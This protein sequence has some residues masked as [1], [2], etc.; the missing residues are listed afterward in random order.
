MLKLEDARKTGRYDEQELLIKKPTM[1]G[2]NPN[3]FDYYIINEFTTEETIKFQ[4]QQLVSM[5]SKG[6]PLELLAL[7]PAE[8]LKIVHDHR[9]NTDENYKGLFKEVKQPKTKKEVAEKVEKK[10]VPNKVSKEK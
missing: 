2:I 4:E 10:D 9:M 3:G 5:F 8:Q 1:T 6:I 7:V